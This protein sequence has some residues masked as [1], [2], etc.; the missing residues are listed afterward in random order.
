MARSAVTHCLLAAIRLLEGERVEPQ[1]ERVV[2]VGRQEAG[3]QPEDLRGT[4]PARTRRSRGAGGRRRPGARRRG[5]PSSAARPGPDGRRPRA[6]RPRRGFARGRVWLD[7]AARAFSAASRAGA[8][9]SSRNRQMDAPAWAS[10][11]TGIQP[12]GLLEPVQGAP[13]PAEQAAHRLRR[14]GPARRW[15]PSWRGGRTRRC[16]SCVAP[17]GSPGWG[18]GWATGTIGSGLFR[19]P[20]RPGGRARRR[21]R[22]FASFAP[23]RR[24]S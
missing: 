11:E 1:D 10:A 2:A 9:R 12:R 7:T 18:P 23:C 22:G 21:R 14:S 5:A 19:G 20:A 17:R 8:K 4:G 13:A 3:G 15:S 24:R 6:R 16:A